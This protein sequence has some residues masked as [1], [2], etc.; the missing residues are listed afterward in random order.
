MSKYEALFQPIQIGKVSVKNRIMLAPM[1]GTAMIDWMIERRFRPEVHDFYIE[2][3]KDGIGL[4]I[5][6]MVPVRSLFGGAPWL[7][8]HPE[9]FEPVS[10]LVSEIHEYGSKVFFQLGLFSGRNFVLNKAL[11]SF[12]GQ[13]KNAQNEEILHDL[14]IDMVAPDDHEPNVWMPDQFCRALTT[15]EIHE[16]VQAYAKSALLCKKAGCDGVEV[17]AVHEGYLMDQFTTPYTN[18]RTDEYGGSLENRYRFATEV[19][20]EIKK[21]CGEDFPVSLRYSVTSKTR[22]FNQA[23]VPGETFTEVGRTMEESEIAIKL[24]EEAG[25][26]VFNADNGTYDAWF[27]AHPPVYMPLNCNLEDVAHISRFTSKPVYCAGRMQMDTAE[28]AIT[29]GEIAGVAI[30]RQILIDEQYVTKLREDREEDIHPCIACHNGCLAVSTFKGVGAEM[31]PV[32]DHRYCALNSRAFEEKKYTAVPTEK[33]RKIAVIGAGIAGVESAIQEAKRGHEVTLYEKSGRIGG[34]FNEAAAMDFK[35]KDKELLR[36]YERELMKL[37]VT[38][39]FHTEINDLDALEA[40]EVIIATGATPRKLDIPGAE[41]AVDAS[42]FLKNQAIAG[43][44]VVIVGGGL[45]GCE[46]A[47]QLALH[48]KK[49]AVVEIVDDLIKAYGVSAANSTMLKEELRYHKVPVYLDSTVKEIT[50]DSVTIGTPD[51]DKTLKADT[52]IVSVGYT[53]YQPFETEG[54]EH[55]HILGDARKVGNLKTAIWSANDLAAELA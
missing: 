26:D 1:E 54:K 18:H 24:L 9:V 3:A 15:D 28:K 37:P 8:D 50:S 46:I 20:R 38:V 23:A 21:L 40:D 48:G 19:I 42:S 44:H 52:V 49:P 55:I 34:V 41:R 2:R 5:P 36:W 29:N 11:A 32:E 45:T 43:E 7:H 4:M 51:G 25:V 12:I 16:Y 30:A 35:E 39:K 22:G 6:G 13:E 17:H 33:P 31:L 53:P 47:Y 14:D 27:W 10:E